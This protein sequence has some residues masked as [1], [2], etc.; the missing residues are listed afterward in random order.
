MNTPLTIYRN[1]PPNKYDQQPKGTICLVGGFP[2][3][4]WEQTHEDSENPLWLLVDDTRTHL[5]EIQ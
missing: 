3:E 5:L 4:I 2:H 1:G